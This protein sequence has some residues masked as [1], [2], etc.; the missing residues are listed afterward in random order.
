MPLLDSGTGNAHLWILS[1]GS[2]DIQVT[3]SNGDIMDRKDQLH[4]ILGWLHE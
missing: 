3:P 2:S 4:N 1:H